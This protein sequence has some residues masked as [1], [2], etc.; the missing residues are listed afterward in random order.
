[1][2]IPTTVLVVDDNPL[3]TQAT[4]RL[5]LNA[6]FEVVEANSG[7]DC[8]SIASQL[9]PDLI[10]L[11]VVMPDLSG[12]DVCRQIKSDPELSSTYV[13]MFSGTK[14]E[15]VE[16]AHGLEL[17]AD[18]YITRPISNRELLAR[19]QAMLRIKAAE[20]ESARYAAE[21]ERSNQELGDFAYILSH[22]LNEPLRMVHSFL[23]LLQKRYADQLDDEANEFIEYAVN[24][25]DRMK[26]MID[27][28]LVYSRIGTLGKTFKSIAL[29]DVLADALGNLK[30]L[31]EENQV[32]INSDPLPSVMADRAQ[33]VQL[34]QNLISNAIKFR[35]PDG[36]KIDIRSEKQTDETVVSF[37]DNGIGI[38]PQNHERIFRM[39]QRLHTR[40]EYPGMGAG[41]AIC[42]RIIERHG[43]RIWV[44]SESGAGATFYISF[45]IAETDSL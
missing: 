31:I 6:G 18:G 17:G 9:K 37:Q 22:D 10:L 3:H 5:L 32:E 7:R 33:I 39:F 24:G 14:R 45:P 12:F 44:A 15:S 13:I 27:S 41:L 19:V 40:N 25:A 35:N 11:D 2:V 43:G 20:E 23:G 29:D 1:M 36:S 21:L 26:A 4:A 16:Q 38:D 42:K 8:L 34:F 30:L 28:L